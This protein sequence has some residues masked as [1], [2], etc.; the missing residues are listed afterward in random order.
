MTS[1]PLSPHDF[2]RFSRKNEHGSSVSII[3]AGLLKRGVWGA[4]DALCWSWGLV[5]SLANGQLRADV[6]F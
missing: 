6:Q 2:V 3:N 1:V 5:S 4:V